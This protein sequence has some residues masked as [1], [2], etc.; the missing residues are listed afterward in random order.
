MRKHLCPKVWLGHS[1]MLGSFRNE[2]LPVATL[3]SFFSGKSSFAKSADMSRKTTAK[4]K[5]KPSLCCEM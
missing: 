1:G 3:Q 5:H 4:F 2:Y